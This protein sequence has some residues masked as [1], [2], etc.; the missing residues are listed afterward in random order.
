RLD[1]APVRKEANVALTKSTK[2]VHQRLSGYTQTHPPRRPQQTY[3]RTFTLKDSIQFSIKPFGT[4]GEGRIFTALDYAPPVMGHDSQTEM[5]AGRWWTEKSV[6]EE[7][8]PI[9]INYFN[10]ALGKV[11]QAIAGGVI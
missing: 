5:F 7:Q 10:E 1:K 2:A 4:S 6:A 9:I 8:M 11:A 3:I